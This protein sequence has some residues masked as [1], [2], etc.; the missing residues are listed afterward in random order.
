MLK[1]FRQ[2]WEDVSKKE[3]DQV[4]KYA[5]KLFAAVGLDIAFTKHFVDFILRFI[6]SF[7]PNI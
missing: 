1:T 5:D 3:L 2:F 4:E 7:F 6:I